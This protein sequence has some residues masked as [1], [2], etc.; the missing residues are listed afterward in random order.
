MLA[1][2]VYNKYV[3]HAYLNEFSHL[4]AIVFTAVQ[5]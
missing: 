1:H 4:T 5:Q 3:K 2:Q